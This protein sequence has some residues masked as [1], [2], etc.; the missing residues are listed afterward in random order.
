M[1][2]GGLHHSSGQ[3]CWATPPQFFERLAGRF[4]FKLDA[5]AQEWSAK[6]A[7]WYSEQDDGLA[8]PWQSWTWCNPPYSRVA[9]WLQKAHREATLGNSSVILMFARTDTRAFHQWALNASEI[10]F[11]KGRL[12]FIDPATHQPGMTAPS[13]SMLVIFEAGKLGDCRFTTM[14][15]K[16]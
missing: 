5:C 11:L 13:P 16:V 3:D 10:V 2:L 15:A 9:D 8:L 6:C 12:K 14:S 1:T 4:D 7:E